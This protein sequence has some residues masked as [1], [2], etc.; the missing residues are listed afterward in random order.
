MIAA[1]VIYGTDKVL[2]AVWG[3]LPKS[4]VAVD[5]NHRGIVKLTFPKGTIAKSLG[6][7]QPGQ[8]VS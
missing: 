7:Y 8:Y 2:R 5:V 4:T 1:V 3:L 6:V